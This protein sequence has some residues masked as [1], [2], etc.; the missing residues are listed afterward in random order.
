[1]EELLKNI[2]NTV[3]DVSGYSGDLDYSWDLVAK[4]II[5]SVMLLE[6]ISIIEEEYDI[7]V[8][9]QHVFDG[10]FASINSI[11]GFVNSQKG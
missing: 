11:A 9:A 1:M 3:L 4:R 8:T 5:K 10:H 7:E 2:E 6:I